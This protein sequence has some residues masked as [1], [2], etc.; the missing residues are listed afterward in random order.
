MKPFPATTP[1]SADT[2]EAKPIS[3]PTHIRVE[4]DGKGKLTFEC[5]VTEVEIVDRQLNLL[6]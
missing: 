2:I 4:K 3:L 6:K 1:R 5:E